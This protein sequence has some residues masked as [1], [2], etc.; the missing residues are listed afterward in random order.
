MRAENEGVPES[1]ERKALARRRAVDT[2]RLAAAVAG[3]AAAQLANGIGPAEAR[4]AVVDAAIELETAAGNLRRLAR[5]SLSPA[6][7]RALAVQLVADGWSQARAA[8]LSGIH[9]RTLWN[10][11]RSGRAHGFLA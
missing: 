2:L 4:R 6:E 8:E 7:R 3:Y 1:A 10:E 5:L 9:Q 11:L